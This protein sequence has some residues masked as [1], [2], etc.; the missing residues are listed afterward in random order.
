VTGLVTARRRAGGRTDDVGFFAEDDWTLGPVVLTAGG[1]L[2]RWAITQG[3]YQELNPAGTVVTA[4][5]VGDPAVAPRSGWYGSWRAG[6]V[7]H[8]ASWLA[9]RGSGY[10]GLRMPTLNELYRSFRVTAPNSTTITNRNPALANERL[11]GFEGGIDLTP[12]RGVTL[13]VTG[14]DNKVRDA[15][16]NVTLSTVTS[17]ASTTTTRERRNVGAVHARGVEVATRIERGQVALSGSFAYTDA[18][19]EAPGTNMDGMR[20][21]QTPR[22]AGSATLSW[23]PAP[24]WTGAL[25]VRHTGL[26]Y[27]DDL[28]SAP[29]APATTLDAFAQIPLTTWASLTLRGENLFD[30]TIVTRNSGGSIDIG[31]P[32]TLWAGLR[33]ACA[34][35]HGTPRNPGCGF[36]KTNPI[37]EAGGSCSPLPHSLGP[38]PCCDQSGARTKSGLVGGR[39]SAYALQREAASWAFRARFCC[40]TRCW[41]APCGWHGMRLRRWGHGKDGITGPIHAACQK[42]QHETG[43]HAGGARCHEPRNHV[44]GCRNRRPHHRRAAPPR[45]QG[46]TR[47]QAARLVHRHLPDLARRGD[48]PLDGIHPQDL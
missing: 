45:G 17:G 33:S 10:T 6:A 37:R 13:S 43:P 23:S 24:R 29:L 5:S 19:V 20:P 1:R 36:L 15:I 11:L 14:F 39:S 2:D 3:H 38:K 9:L 42:V 4:T 31:T 30:E 28:Q 40:G 21:S 7:V 8:A 27:E 12:A 16:A 47:G 41:P 34:E 46:R 32:R 18:K 22:I 48:R 35:F 44:Q 26:A 25:T